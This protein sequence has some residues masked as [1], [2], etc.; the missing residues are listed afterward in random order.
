MNDALFKEKMKDL[1][2]HS[3]DPDFRNYLE[4]QVIQNSSDFNHLQLCIK[5]FSDFDSEPLIYYFLCI[6]RIWISSDIEMSI[7]LLSEIKNIFFSKL[8][9]SSSLLNAIQTS[10]QIQIFLKVYPSLIPSFWFD[11]ISSNA[12]PEIKLNFLSEFSSLFLDNQLKKQQRTILLNQMRNDKSKLFLFQY[13]LQFIVNE[14]SEDSLIIMAKLLAFLDPFEKNSNDNEVINSICSS[15]I[16]SIFPYILN[17]LS[18]M[19]QFIF[20]KQIESND[21]DFSQLNQIISNHHQI[22]THIG[23]GVTFL[24]RLISTNFSQHQIMGQIIPQFCE[25]I[26]I[27]HQFSIGLI[28]QLFDIQNSSKLSLLIELSNNLKIDLNNDI[29]S[30]LTAVGNFISI[31]TN[32]FANS[33]LLQSFYLPISLSLLRTP[34]DSVSSTVID[35]LKKFSMDSQNISI[36]EYTE[37]V[38]NIFFALAN[39]LTIF[40]LKNSI[41]TNEFFQSLVTAFKTVLPKVNPKTKIFEIYV[42]SILTSHDQIIASIIE[43]SELKVFKNINPSLFELP[44]LSS[45]LKVLDIAK[46]KFINFSQ[47]GS[48]LATCQSLLDI[49]PPINGQQFYSITYYMKYIRRVESTI[50]E[51]HPIFQ[52]VFDSLI[53]FLIFEG[54]LNNFIDDS[55]EVEQISEKIKNKF[56][57]IA[58]DYLTIQ[59]FNTRISVSIDQILSLIRTKNDD[60]VLIVSNILSKVPDKETKFNFFSQCLS[61]LYST[62]DNRVDSILRILSFIQNQS[63][64][65]EENDSELNLVQYFLQQLFDTAFKSEDIMVK[66]LTVIQKVLDDRGIELFIKCVNRLYNEVGSPCFSFEVV[67]LMCKNT[68]IY[69]QHEIQG[70]WKFETFSKVF[71]LLN[72]FQNFDVQDWKSQQS[73]EVRE[74]TNLL[75]NFFSLA[76]HSCSFLGAEKNIQ[77]LNYL[78]GHV[79]IL[80][81]L[82]STDPLYNSFDYLYSLADFLTTNY[83]DSY[84]SV[85]S[86][87]IERF[88]ILTFSIFKS[89]NF[90]VIMKWKKVVEITFKFNQKLM[91]I[92]QD[93]TN[94]KLCEFFAQLPQSELMMQY[95]SAY[96]QLL[97]SETQVYEILDTVEQIFQFLHDECNP[98]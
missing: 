79:N 72:I 83:D 57:S 69:I 82:N 66:Y 36:E 24:Y 65:S 9:A 18:Q 20:E 14:K 33:D 70:D 8:K 92:N 17:D 13:L 3:F 86:F 21:Q 40:Y 37:K 30:I 96:I 28:N 47:I 58:N 90:L 7:E 87:L 31:C 62:S 97:C 61:N 67:S 53:N 38:K 59:N 85:V 25:K 41:D 12:P 55:N 91:Q 6:F 34:N 68:N 10:V 89:N 77:I 2:S 78:N 5:Y 27:I 29:Y 19:P 54:N 46:D 98:D 81:E 93:A 11:F 64:F 35:F 88:L 16:E 48:V 51:R 39:R 26:N 60:I 63:T 45:M 73:E 94:N 23:N 50:D 4:Q 75:I 52:L 71:D 44:V 1:I 43:S 49:K 76:A 32:K 22:F 74:I 84:S 15:I 80:F 56:I 95:Q 42:Q